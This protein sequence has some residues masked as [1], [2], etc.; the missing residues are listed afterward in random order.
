M[1]Y[2]DKSALAFCLA[3]ALSISLANT[4]N[5]VTL[6][7]IGNCSTVDTPAPPIPFFPT[8]P[9][10]LNIDTAIGCSGHLTISNLG[11]PSISCDGDLTFTGASLTSD[12]AL[13]LSATNDFFLKHVSLSAPFV[14]LS[15]G[16]MLN[17]DADSVITGKT[18]DLSAGTMLLNGQI[19][20]VPEPSAVFLTILGL[21]VV[22]SRK[23]TRRHQER[24]LYVPA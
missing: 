9:S 17:M 12:T 15:A 2:Y 22:A 7:V 13:Y 8:G 11:K 16:A 24:G 21:G 23:L 6:C 18:I 14:S 1:V 19:N 3:A 4:A 20:P 10:T 5:A